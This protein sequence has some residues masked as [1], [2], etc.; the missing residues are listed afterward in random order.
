M[1]HEAPITPRAK[2]QLAPGLEVWRASTMP[3]YRNGTS[4]NRVTLGVAER[5]DGKGLEPYLSTNGDPMLVSYHGDVWSVGVPAVAQ[6]LG[7]SVDT[8][9][10]LVKTKIPDIDWPGAS[11]EARVD[12]SNV[13]IRARGQE[14]INIARAESS[15]DEPLWLSAMRADGFRADEYCLTIEEAEKIYATDPDAVF[16]TIGRVGWCVIGRAFGRDRVVEGPF[17]TRDEAFAA[18]RPWDVGRYV[19]KSGY[20]ANVDFHVAL[21]H[22]PETFWH[23]VRRLDAERQLAKQS[24]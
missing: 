2:M 5:C 9:I 3:L 22:T 6:A 10:R 7:L 8:V 12:L 18:M 24:R 16:L 14:A 15:V 4:D 17:R 23:M 19:N 13:P 11:S 21:R 1:T 20:A